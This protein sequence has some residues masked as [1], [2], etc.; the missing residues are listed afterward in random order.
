MDDFQVVIRALWNFLEKENQPFQEL[1][2]NTRR[3]TDF[4]AAI[5]QTANP[6][7]REAVSAHRESFE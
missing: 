5:R 6:A 2:R 7:F 3:A 4:F 1:H